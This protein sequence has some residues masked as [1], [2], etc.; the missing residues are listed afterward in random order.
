[1]R[2]VHW[3]SKQALYTGRSLPL[4]VLSC[5][6]I[7]SEECMEKLLCFSNRM[8]SKLLGLTLGK[9]KHLLVL[10][11]YKYGSNAADATRRINKAWGNRTVGES[12]VRE[13]FG[14]FKAGNEEL[15]DRARS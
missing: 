7:G 14:E 3:Q 6:H 12:I 2:D 9:L 4:R 15:T 8:E 1:M 10:Y 5:R 13:R 11:D